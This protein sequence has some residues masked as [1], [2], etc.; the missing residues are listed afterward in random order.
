MANYCNLINIAISHDYF[1]DG[2]CRALQFKPTLATTKLIQRNNLLIKPIA[3]GFNILGDKDLSEI[4]DEEVR[5]RFI[6]YSQDPHFLLYTAPSV[7]DDEQLFFST[8][9][10]HQN[11]LSPSCFDNTAPDDDMLDAK[12]FGKPVFILDIHIPPTI[13]TEV[14]NSIKEFTLHFSARSLHWKY[15]FFGDLMKFD[16][17]INDVFTQPAITFTNSNTSE[18]LGFK[19]FIS[20]APLLL[21]EVPKQKFQLKDKNNSGKVLIKRLANAGVTRLGK[22]VSKDGEAFIVAEIYVNQ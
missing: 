12:R 11:R 9:I 18:D 14:E 6:T 5:L 1:I 17:E 3:T 21:C 7:N 10:V 8:Q 13:F 20:H 15:Y 2:I 4:F 22:E 19:A 16:L